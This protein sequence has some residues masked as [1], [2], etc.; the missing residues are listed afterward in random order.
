MLWPAILSFVYP[1]PA[2]VLMTV[3]AVIST[4]GVA[5]AGLSEI[6]GSHLKYSK[7]WNV[8][9]P[10]KMEM[11]RV[12]SWTGMLVLYVPAFLV[13]AASFWA[14]PS[15]DGGLRFLLLRSALTLHFLKRVLEVLLIHKFSGFMAVD[16]MCSISLSYSVFTAT[17]IY[18]QHISRGLPDP[19]ID[20]T[21]PGLALFAIGMAGNFYHHLILSR[22][23]SH[24]SEKEYTV[25]RGG[26]F[27]YVTCPH[28]LFEI[29]DFMGISLISQT[30]YSF[31][32]TIATTIYLMGR[33]YATRRWYLAK[34]DDFPRDVK[35]LFPFVY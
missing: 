8:S 17:S 18:T 27:D 21:Y 4:A 31:A 19:I 5:N 22:L 23:R 14:F 7:F 13:G 35:A 2:S 33:S 32:F 24:R 1:P 28:Y 26:L 29:I 20:L 3:V 25:P 34:F 6:R 10:C 12:S 11:A 30:V 15:G 16:S 9:S